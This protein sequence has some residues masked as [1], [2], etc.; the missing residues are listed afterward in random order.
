MQRLLGSTPS[1]LPRDGLPADASVV[2]ERLAIRLEQP[3]LPDEALTGPRG[4]A[5]VC[6]SWRVRSGAPSPARGRPRPAS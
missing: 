2:A 4:Q 3:A 1:A 6:V 5:S